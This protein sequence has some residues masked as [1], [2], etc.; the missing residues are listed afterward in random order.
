MRMSYYESN[1]NSSPY[2]IMGVGE[3]PTIPYV[4]FH[5]AFFNATGKRVKQCNLV[6]ARTLAAM[7]KI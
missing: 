5:N 1:N 4:A 6:P 3:P 2:G 7:G